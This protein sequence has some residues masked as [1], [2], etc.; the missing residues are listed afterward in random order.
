[1][2]WMMS[3]AVRGVVVVKE[4]PESLLLVKRGTSPPVGERDF[5]MLGITLPVIGQVSAHQ[6]MANW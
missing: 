4:P 5:V 2:P 1:M 3:T 6:V